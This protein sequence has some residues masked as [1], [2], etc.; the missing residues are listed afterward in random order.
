MEEGYDE[1]RMLDFYQIEPSIQIDYGKDYDD[2]YIWSFYDLLVGNT[3]LNDRYK[4]MQYTGLKDKFKKEVYDGD[5]LYDVNYR[6][7]MCIHWSDEGAC[8]TLGSS[9]DG[10]LRVLLIGKCWKIIGNIYENP[11]LV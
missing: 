3:I 5:I 1:E 2:E 8:W 6:I 11:E 4:I 10:N 7:K 9:K